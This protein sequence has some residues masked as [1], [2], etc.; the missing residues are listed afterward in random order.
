[1][2]KRK[3]KYY[4]NKGESQSAKKAK[5]KFGDSYNKLDINQKGFLITYN[6]KFT[7]CLNE[8]KKLLQQ[9]TTPIDTTPVSD[10]ETEKGNDLEKELQQELD[11]LNQRDKEFAVLDTGAKYTIFIKLN[12]VDTNKVVEDIFEHMEK[13]KKP[14]GRFIQRLLP[15]ANTCKA[16]LDDI[17]KCMKTTLEGFDCLSKP[18]KYCCVY[19]TSNNSSI[20]R[21]DVFRMVGTHFQ[22]INPA[23]KVDF[24][25][26]E[27]V[28]IFTVICKICFI[29]F[30]KNYHEYKRYNLV[31]QGNKYNNLNK[32]NQ[33]TD[34]IQTDDN[35]QNN[36]ETILDN[37]KVETVESQSKAITL[38]NND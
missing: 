10:K 28:L 9:F 2:G 20:K 4:H 3:S 6:C 37:V 13:T 33:K 18:V 7:F 27:Y 22:S 24:D 36:Q 23:N 38:T 31:E 30:V 34:A 35:I 5:L 14:L 1:M 15:I 26:P 25:A 11:T 29:S 16:F 32:N 8:S 12:S 17:E 19:K 21:E